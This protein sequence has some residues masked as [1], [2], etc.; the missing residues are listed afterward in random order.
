[1]PN[2]NHNTMLVLPTDI[3][4]KNRVDYVQIGFKNYMKYNIFKTNIL[5]CSKYCNTGVKIVHI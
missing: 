5:M 4:N 3:N 2:R 1:M